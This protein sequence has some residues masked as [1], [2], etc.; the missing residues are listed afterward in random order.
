MSTH[1]LND[2]QLNHAAKDLIVKFPK[3]ERLPKDPPIAGQLYGAYSFKLLPKPVNGVY[4]FLKFR[5]AF[6]TLDEFEKHARAIIKSYDSKHHIFPFKTG[7]WAPITVNEDF[8]KEV[9]S[10]KENDEIV[11]IFNNRQTEEQKSEAQKVK[12]VKDRERIL[13][14]QARKKE[15]DKSTIEYYTQKLMSIEQ[16]ESWLD[17]LRKR[18]RQ[19]RRALMDYKSEVDRIEKE[20]PEYKEKYLEERKRI[21]GE[22]G[23][24]ED[25]PLG[26]TSVVAKPSIENG[27]EEEA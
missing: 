15:V 20:H 11:D 23:L 16:V 1:E 8:V 12:E 10:V 5:G 22:I 13:M 4:G 26:E 14:E 9:L 27:K 17:T 7:E 25:A 6:N 19:M 24:P 2:D 18:K 21:L 3:I